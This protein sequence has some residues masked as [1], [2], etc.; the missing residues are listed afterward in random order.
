MACGIS[1]PWAGI[2]AMSPTLQ[3]GVFTAGPPGKSLPAPIASSPRETFSSFIWL[4]FYVL[5][6]LLVIYCCLIFLFYTLLKTSHYGKMKILFFSFVLH[7]IHT[8]HLASQYSYSIILSRLIFCIK[9][10]A[11]KLLQ[12]CLTLCNPIDGS[13]TRLLHPWFF[14]GKSTGVGCHCLLR[15]RVLW[16]FKL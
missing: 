5:L 12:S 2:K 4:F 14:P 15:L 1:V 13:V 16:I 8:H 11:A 9:S 3:G 7:Y 10:F 6:F